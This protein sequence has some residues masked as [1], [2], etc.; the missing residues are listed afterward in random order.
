MSVVAY[1]TLAGL[2]RSWAGAVALVLLVSLVGGA[3]V[4]SVAGA[5]RTDAAVDRFVAASRP[6]DAVVDGPPEVVD[7]L[8]DHPAVEAIDRTVPY[9]VA[10]VGLPA[11]RFVPFAAS[12]DGR[13]LHEFGRPMV[14]DG[15]LADPQ[16]ADEVVLREQTAELLGVG[17]GDV[18]PFESLTDEGVA[19]IDET[20]GDGTD[21]EA[22]PSFDMRVVGLVRDPGDLAARSDDQPFHHLTPAFHQR[23]EGR[24]GTYGQGSFVRLAPGYDL[25]GLWEA[26]GGTGADGYVEPWPGSAGAVAP[27][28]RPTV[29]LLRNAVLGFAAVIAV[30]GIVAV[31]QAQY[32]SAGARAG[33]VGVLSSL[34]LPRRSRVLVLA[35]PGIVAG[36]ASVPG[37]LAV[38]T[39]ASTAFPVGLAHRAELDPGVHFDAVVLRPGALLVGAVVA[40]GSWLGARRVDRLVASGARTKGAPR[41]RRTSLAARTGSPA[42]W[43]GTSFMTRTGAMTPAVPA[44]LGALVAA[45]GLSAAVVF[46]A[47]MTTLLTTPRLYGWTWDI[48]V[49]GTENDPV[50]LRP[51]VDPA[52][53]PAV[54]ETST[55]IA[56][57]ELVIDGR[58]VLA[59]AAGS[60]D[61]IGPV[62]STGRAPTA[63]DEVAIAPETLE[64]LDRAVGDTVEVGAEGA[65]EPFRIV[66]G[67]V[68]PVNGDG[69]GRIDEGASMTLDGL[70]RLGMEP[71]TLCDDDVACT[72]QTVL[73]FHEHADERAT[74]ERLVES[75]DVR[76]SSPSPPGE[77]QRL[78]EVDAAPEL[79][80]TFL[81]LTGAAAVGHA[82]LIAVRRQRRQIA[83]ARCIGFT[84]RQ[85]SGAVL[86]LAVL[87]VAVGAVVG[88]V[89]GV[90][91]GRVLWREVA[92]DI[93]ARP[94]P[95]TP[96]LLVGLPLVVV[97]VAAL[98][99][100]V[101]AHLAGRRGPGAV[102]R[103]E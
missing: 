86:V 29:E 83:V 102:L 46:G 47:S 50:R 66:G 17:V 98:I 88:T 95:T 28:L 35:A 91:G 15:R 53:D 5:R 20:Q 90:V 85:A 19:T 79:L 6:P 78:G 101:P 97:V 12:L 67:A 56:E 9:A 26:V 76:F 7:A 100:A 42:A 34:G 40:G 71:S 49:D 54:D 52:Q 48:G 33:E 64:E 16:A 43:L 11:D 3:V 60:G 2:R 30:A 84:R 36:A 103:A 87:L 55:Y 80:A 21:A 4:A 68:M 51:G 61:R 23:W 59:H 24:I 89:L 13:M 92:L 94:E 63:A 81:A 65:S 57:L 62:V 72:R 75:G 14:V 44:R 77:V 74:L 41:V 39:L 38:A 22:G 31:V 70:R 37:V 69:F 58:P 1:R 25:G 73:R 18:L 45:A 82:V 10:P 99:A 96:G 8:A 32:R 93:G 27:R